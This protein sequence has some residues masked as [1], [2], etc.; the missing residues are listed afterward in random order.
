MNENDQ[1]NAK[2][3]F[4]QLQTLGQILSLIQTLNIDKPKIY[5]SP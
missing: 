3:N 4:E 2:N 5:P 1:E